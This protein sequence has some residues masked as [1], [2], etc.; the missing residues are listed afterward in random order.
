VSAVKIEGSRVVVP[1]EPVFVPVFFSGVTLLFVG[2]TFSI[3]SAVSDFG[4]S[5][6]PSFTPP[7]QA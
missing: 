6:I 5:A 2:T 7:Q 1:P 3:F 4:L